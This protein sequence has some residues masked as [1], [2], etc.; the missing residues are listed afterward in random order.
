[1]SCVLPALFDSV[2]RE[3]SYAPFRVPSHPHSEHNVLLCGELEETFK[4][5]YH[6]VVWICTR[7]TGRLRHVLAR[8]NLFRV[9]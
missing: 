5:G 4:T 1:M 9:I 8:A 6:L 3:R 2:H 7:L